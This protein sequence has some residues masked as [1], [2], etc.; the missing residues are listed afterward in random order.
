LY[1]SLGKQEEVSLVLTHLGGIN[2]TL[3]N[4]H[5]ALRYQEEALSICRRL[6]NKT[7]LAD[8]LSAI[9][10]TSNQLGRYSSADQYLNESLRLLRGMNEPELLASALVQ[11]LNDLIWTCIYSL[12]N[13]D[14]ALATARPSI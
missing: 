9:G 7:R 8:T 10:N 4:Y 5:K 1:R 14:E 3:G 12:S 13:M 2:A 11:G 6:N